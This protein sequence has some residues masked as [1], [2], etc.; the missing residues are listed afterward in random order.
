MNK[1]MSYNFIN[2]VGLYLAKK[3]N[4]NLAS[5]YLFKYA[6]SELSSFKA[7]VRSEENVINHPEWNIF[8][9]TPE[10]ANT[11]RIVD[12]LLAQF[13]KVFESYYNNLIAP[14]SQKPEIVQ[15]ITGNLG[16]GPLAPI[17]PEIPIYELKH[18]WIAKLG[19]SPEDYFTK[20]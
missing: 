11:F 1:I 20:L 12:S 14:L 4:Y 18:N 13:S 5:L 10:F 9:K 2:E 17:N 8:I 6:F 16:N 7:R 19:T 15:G 3:I